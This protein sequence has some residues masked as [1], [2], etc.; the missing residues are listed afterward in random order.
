MI[1]K[2][3]FVAWLKSRGYTPVDGEPDTYE[4]G[5][6]RYTARMQSGARRNRLSAN[7]WSA[8]ESFR[9]SRRR[10]QPDGKLGWR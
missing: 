1:N 5:D 4:K 6:V 2:N 7:R 8:E 9:Y 3:S 10:I